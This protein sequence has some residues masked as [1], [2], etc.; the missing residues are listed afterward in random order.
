MCIYGE[1]KSFECVY[2]GAELTYGKVK[3]VS[4]YYEPTISSKNII[5]SIQLET[6]W[7]EWHWSWQD[8]RDQRDVI[9]KDKSFCLILTRVKPIL[10]HRST[11]SL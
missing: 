4:I 7:N 8:T 5:Y 9:W 3:F 2:D 1:H 11:Y 10:T 6:F